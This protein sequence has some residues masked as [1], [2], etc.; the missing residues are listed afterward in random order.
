MK[1]ILL[2]VFAILGMA[3]CS[4]NDFK[5]ENAVDQN[6]ITF[7]NLNSRTRAANDVSDNYKVYAELST[8]ATSWYIDD[9][10][11]GSGVDLNKAQNGPYYWPNPL[12]NLIF[13][14]YA[15]AA[16]TASSTHPNLT[17]NY[18]VPA[19]AQEDFT[20][21]APVTQQQGTVPF[22]F[23]HMLSKVTIT[24]KLSDALI[25]SGYTIEPA[26]GGYK[27]DLTVAANNGTFNVKTKALTAGTPATVAYSNYN[28]YMVMPQSSIGLKIQVRNF[29]IKKNG[30]EMFSGDLS[31]FTTIAGNV[32]G[33]VLTGNKHYK[34]T[35]EINSISTDS[36]NAPIF[37]E[38]FFDA[39]TAPWDDV[40]INA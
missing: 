1:K 18:T 13:Y 3:S 9:V 32:T 31:E 40:D 26:T 38:I 27:A 39:T 10:V 25:A 28:S 14:S 8:G 19:T 21:A 4:N 30:V 12:A 16:L 34:V 2:G 17:V 33:D 22:V 20:I 36:N 37:N 29:I 5:E 35:M 23:T 6:T 15:P 24:P 7:S 11:N